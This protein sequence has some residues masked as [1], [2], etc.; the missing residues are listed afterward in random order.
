MCCWCFEW[1]LLVVQL[2]PRCRHRKRELYTLKTME[3]VTT[4]INGQEVNIGVALK[5]ERRSFWMSLPFA[6]HVLDFTLLMGALQDLYTLYG[7]EG[8]DEFLVLWLEDEGQSPSRSEEKEIQKGTG[9]WGGSFPVPIVSD[10][11]LTQ[12]LGI[13]IKGLAYRYSSL[14]RWEL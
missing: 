5:S 13:T 2:H 7:P 9:R 1:F 14:P 11:N 10:P 12:S 6:W 8:T 3:Y 4:D